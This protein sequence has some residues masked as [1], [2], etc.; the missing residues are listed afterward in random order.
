MLKKHPFYSRAG[1]SRFVS[2]PVLLKLAMHWLVN[3]LLGLGP[4][5]APELFLE[6]VLVFIAQYSECGS[7]S[8]L[9]C[10][11]FALVP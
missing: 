10:G 9:T 6:G 7:G 8:E 5:G 4:G 11:K 1:G 3:R 2:M